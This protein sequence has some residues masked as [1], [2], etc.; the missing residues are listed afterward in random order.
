[1]ASPA[2][3]R[4]FIGRCVEFNIQGRIQI[5]DDC[6]IASGCVFVDHD[7]GM[8]RTRPMRGQIQDVRPIRIGSNVWIGANAV[9][10]KGIE[11]GDGAVVGAGSIVTKSIPGDEIWCGNPARKL[12]ERK[13]E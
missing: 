4:V 6:L 8:D 12:R 10:L 3:D 7:H 1:M 11:I 5:G 9:I 2:K 13:Q